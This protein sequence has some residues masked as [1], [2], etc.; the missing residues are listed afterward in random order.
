MGDWEAAD[1]GGGN[2]G[3]GAGEVAAVEDGG[4][5]GRERSRRGRFWL[6]LQLHKCR[7]LAATLQ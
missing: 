2:G 4:R 3:Q 6:F 5:R 1:G 7:G